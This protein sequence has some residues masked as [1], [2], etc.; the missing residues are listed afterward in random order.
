M[1]TPA[2]ALTQHLIEVGMFKPEYNEDIL[3][4]I[5]SFCGAPEHGVGWVLE[6]Q[7]KIDQ[8]LAGGFAQD[9]VG[10]GWGA[11]GGDQDMDPWQKAMSDPELPVRLVVLSETL[12]QSG[13][14]VPRPMLEFVLAFHKDP[15]EAAVWLSSKFSEPVDSARA[16]FGIYDQDIVPNVPGLERTIIDQD[17]N[18]RPIFQIRSVQQK[19]GNACGYHAIHN[20]SAVFEMLCTTANVV[21]AVERVQMVTS[22][23]GFVQRFW[24]MQH[25]LKQG[26]IATVEQIETNVM[27]RHF[28]TYVIA[29]EQNI[30]SFGGADRFLCVPDVVSGHSPASLLHE[31]QAIFDRFVRAEQHCHGFIIGCMDHWIACL[32]HRANAESQLELLVLNSDNRLLLSS[33]GDA[34]LEAAV[35]MEMAGNKESALKSIQRHFKDENLTPD[36][37]EDI[38]L[39]GRPE[40]GINDP[41]YWNWRPRWVRL[42][43]DVSTRRAAQDM[44]DIIW[45]CANGQASVLNWFAT[46]LLASW[47]GS[48]RETA[49]NKDGIL[50]ADRQT[51]EG[52]HCCGIEH[53]V[54][55]VRSYSDFRMNFVHKLMEIG[56]DHLTD[57]Q[58]AQLKSFVKEIEGAIKA[59]TE[60]LSR[61]GTLSA[62]NGTPWI[63]F[64]LPVLDELFE[65]VQGGKPGQDAPPS[66]GRALADRNTALMAMEQ[67][68][69]DLASAIMA[70]DVPACKQSASALS[71]AY[72]SS[73][74]LTRQAS[75]RV[76]EQ[77]QRE[78]TELQISRPWRPTLA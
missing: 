32:L 73:K 17:I 16:V 54:S 57:E 5:L 36:Q 18:S 78:P 25:C 15:L 40:P 38:Y 53:W 45:K 7:D 65:F 70:G 41:Q 19:D 39:N 13:V 24:N 74:V 64:F 35:D 44:T 1:A 2:G 3:N 23:Q 26:G 62:A 63:H 58:V 28:A 46:R 66:A 30:S 43:T 22:E 20:A 60:K 61:Q 69:N 71:A 37:L 77:M 33:W 27:E 76:K 47:F 12:Q 75:D 67:A 51:D 52:G 14:S 11:V 8:W 21:E 4:K 34:A 48:F 72:S 29:N 49:F 6:N 9:A 59:N 31:W 50:V 56:L 68:E 55:S 42:Q 10:G